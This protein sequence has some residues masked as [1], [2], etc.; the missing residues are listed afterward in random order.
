MFNEVIFKGLSLLGA[1]SKTLKKELESQF[2]PLKFKD[3]NDGH[4]PTRE[5][6][7]FTLKFTHLEILNGNN[8]DVLF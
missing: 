8:R 1:L 4:F 3:I 5:L 2:S 6:T 7:E